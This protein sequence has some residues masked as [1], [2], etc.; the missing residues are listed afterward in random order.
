VSPLVDE[1]AAMVREIEALADKEFLR[2]ID[3][4]LSSLAEE[5]P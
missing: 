3:E 1:I 2:L 5:L 4:F